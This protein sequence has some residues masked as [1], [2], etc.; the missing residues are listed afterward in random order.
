MLQLSRVQ[1]TGDSDR[2]RS[3]LVVL[4][5]HLSLTLTCIFFSWSALTNQ[6]GCW[7]GSWPM[8]CCWGEEDLSLMLDHWDT[9][10]S[11][12]LQDA[13]SQLKIPTDEELNIGPLFHLSSQAVSVSQFWVIAV[14]YVLSG[15]LHWYLIFAACWVNT[16][17]SLKWL[18]RSLIKYFID[19][20]LE[21]F[22]LID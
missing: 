16:E 5:L 22:Q 7:R 18:P 1:V 14:K 8:E 3:K 6:R 17:S 10:C 11:M 4:Y 19:L 12:E 13:S 15:I 2:L 9:T 21:I 20:V